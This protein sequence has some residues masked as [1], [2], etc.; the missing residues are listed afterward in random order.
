MAKDWNGDVDCESDSDEGEGEDE[1]GDSQN[2]LGKVIYTFSKR[3]YEVFLIARV[4]SGE[5][6]GL[7]FGRPHLR[8]PRG[9]VMTTSSNSQV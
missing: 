9:M 2:A 1:A 8:A 5:S 3:L 6:G 7:N 4:I